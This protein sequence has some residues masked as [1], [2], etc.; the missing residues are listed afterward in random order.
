MS[1]ERRPLKHLGAKSHFRGVGE[2]PKSGSPGQHSPAGPQAGTPQASRTT[3]RA[4]TFGKTN[5]CP[6]WVGSSGLSG[7]FRLFGAAD[8]FRLSGFSS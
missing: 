2:R 5:L 1:P 8:L 4:L 6:V 3:H 7:S